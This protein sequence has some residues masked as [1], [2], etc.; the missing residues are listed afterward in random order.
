MARNDDDIEPVTAS[1]RVPKGSEAA[2]SDF[3]YNL[4]RWWP[5][6]HTFFQDDFAVATIEPMK[7][8]RWYET[9]KAGR[10][11]VWG[12]VREFEPPDKV[13]L[14]YAVSPDRHSE[15]PERASEVEILFVPEHGIQSREQPATSIQITHSH[16]SRHGEGAKAMRDQLAS[17]QG[18]PL[19]LSSFARLYSA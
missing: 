17:P 13:V 10:R 15:P 4:R 8:G 11:M 9:N 14:S 7:G 19:I 2:F 3:I 12:D 6:A 1:V 16:F 18:W 5:L